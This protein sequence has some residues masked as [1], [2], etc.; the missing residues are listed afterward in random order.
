VHTLDLTEVLLAQALGEETVGLKGGLRRSL[1]DRGTGE[2]RMGANN[3]AH[4]L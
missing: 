2:L 3:S 4:A 1:P